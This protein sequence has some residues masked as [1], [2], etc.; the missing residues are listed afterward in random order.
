MRELGEK[1]TELAQIAQVAYQEGEQGILELLDAYRVALLSQRR[2][3]ELLAAAKRAEIELDRAVGEE[4][5][6]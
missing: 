6:P 2:A 5:L 1:S 4:V 3:L